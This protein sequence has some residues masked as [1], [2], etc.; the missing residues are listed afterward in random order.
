MK[1]ADAMVMVV[2]AAIVSIVW[3]A[4]HRD[5]IDDDSPDY[6]VAAEN[7]A[8][9]RGMLSRPSPA[10]P[11]AWRSEA[12]VAV[13]RLSELQGD[14][15]ATRTPGYPLFLALARLAGLTPRGATFV[16]H[17]LHV[18]LI[19]AFVV[20]A[21]RI[22]AGRGTTIAAAL[23]LI[24]E[25]YGR[26]AANHIVSETLFS[27]AVFAIV[28]LVAER[29][30][31]S[32]GRAA[33][34]GSLC[35]AATLIRPIAMLYCIPVAIF[36]VRRVSAAVLLIVCALGPPAAWAARNASRTGI[37]TLSLIVPIN[38]LFYTA[39]GAEATSMPG[40]FADNLER[41]RDSER[42]RLE[43]MIGGRALTAKEKLDVVNA[44]ANDILRHHV[45]GALLHAARDVRALLLITNRCNT[46]GTLRN[47]AK[48]VL[49]CI[50]IAILLL[51]ILGII[52]QRDRAIALFFALTIIY[53]IC[54]GAGSGGSWGRFRVPVEPFYAL[55][56]ATGGA[57]VL[58]RLQRRAA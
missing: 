15:E 32:L 52:V 44:L 31:M 3:A 18:A 41:V 8:E 1:R 37:F 55:C 10:A 40:R 47:R 16:Q 43:A 51:A 14:V 56:A 46:C 50:H 30:E 9:G 29:R 33:L 42:T 58:Q 5:V 13:T 4:T 35:A 17:A 12:R 28:W 21:R 34:V 2:L 57:A 19:G 38:R 6:I 25:P 39:A 53:F 24:A 7:L 49:L 48:D 45:R 27:V 22:G 36:G 11:E 54:I 26:W 20:F 23:W